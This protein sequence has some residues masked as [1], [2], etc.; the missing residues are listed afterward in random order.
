MTTNAVFYPHAMRATAIAGGAEL[1]CVTLI[2]DMRPAHGFEDLVTFDA[3]QVGPNFVGS[4]R[5]IPDVRLTT[6]Q[7]GTLLPTFVSGDYYV[8][9]DLSL[10]NVDHY[11]RSG[12]NLGSRVAAGTSSHLQ[13]RA[14]GNSMLALESISASEGQLASLTCRNAPVLGAQDPLVPTGAIAL[15]GSAVGGSLFTMGPVKLNGTFLQGGVYAGIDF[16]LE[17]EEESSHGDGFLTYVGIRRYRPV[18]TVRTRKT[19]YMASFGQRGTALS[20]CV[21]YLTNKLA[22]GINAA[23]ASSVHLK[24]TTATSGVIKAREV[25]GD[26]SMVELTIE[27]VQTAQDTAPVVIAVNQQIT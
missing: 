12:V 23:A 20:S 21:M 8:S 18:I 27:P 16:N 24:I 1:F 9:R 6:P 2:D 4:H 10:Y 14:S 17:Y 5:A 22:S 13:F 26:R 15:G 3:A 25:Q 7:L 19:D 11:Y